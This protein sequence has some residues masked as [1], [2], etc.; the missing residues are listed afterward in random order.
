M[1]RPRK[2]PTFNN[3]MICGNPFEV[4][5]NQHK[6]KTCSPECRKQELVNRRLG[7]HY[8]G[9]GG[10]PRATKTHETCVICGN[11]FPLKVYQA[12]QNKQTCSAECRNQYYSQV[13][14]G[15]GVGTC[16]ICGREYKV[17]RFHLR[18]GRRFCGDE[19]RM[20]WFSQ[21]TPTGEKNPY[22]KGGSIS[23][24]GETWQAA[25]RA[26][27]KRDGHACSVC[28]KHKTILGYEPIVHHIKPFKA[29]GVDRHAEANQL[30]NLQCLCRS[31][32]MKIEWATVR[33]ISNPSS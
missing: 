8:A 19:C 1:A 14:G 30:D 20:Q 6:K 11:V 24:Y 33:N 18:H 16:E 10:K 3:C 9:K 22:W 29:F 21:Q 28:G 2:S 15:L 5:P 27:R 4:T 13:R 25:R 17:S 32:H 7:K 12:L 26:A 31:C 23:Y